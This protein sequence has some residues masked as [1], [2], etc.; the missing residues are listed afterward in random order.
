MAL[1]G[2]V[3]WGIG[4]AALVGS[5]LYLN[6][7]NKRYARVATERRVKVEAEVRLLRTALQEIERLLQRTEEQ[8]RGCLDELAWL[9]GHAGGNYQ[10]FSEG[11]KRRLAALIDHIRPLSKLLNEEVAL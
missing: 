5:G 10:R 11:Q 8:V 6:S 1:A 4:G 2:P 7:R 9:N 3:G